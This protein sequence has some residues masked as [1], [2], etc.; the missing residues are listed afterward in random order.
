LG[1]F[2]LTALLPRTMDS[3]ATSFGWDAKMSTQTRRAAVEQYRRLNEQRQKDLTQDSV[4]LISMT[5]QLRD[6]VDDGSRKKLTLDT[7]K[8]VAEIEKLAHEVKEKMK[9]VYAR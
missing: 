3:Q 1:I 7:V 8:K 2:V 4:R 6:E 9:I 5:S